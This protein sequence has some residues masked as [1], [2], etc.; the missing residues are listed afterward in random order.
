MS[1]SLEEALGEADVR[2]NI[3]ND[4]VRVIDQEV[5]RKSGITGMALRAGYAFVSKLQGGQMVPKAVDGLLDEFASAIQ[6]LHAA[7]QEQGGT[8]GFGPFLVARKAEASNALLAITD[9]RAERHDNRALVS[10]YRKL[11]PTAIR[12]VEEALPAVGGLIDRYTA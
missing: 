2:P 3:V 8:G 5:E 4:T 12:H 7:Y 6:P 1:R 10:A 9:K 11:R